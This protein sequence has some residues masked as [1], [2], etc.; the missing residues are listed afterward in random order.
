MYGPDSEG[1]GGGEPSP[2][3]SLSRSSRIVCEGSARPKQPTMR[4]AAGGR[5]WNVKCQC[6]IFERCKD[7][8]W[9]YQGTLS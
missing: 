6:V 3:S 8:R 7:R 9:T 5:R 1:G 2:S 4:F